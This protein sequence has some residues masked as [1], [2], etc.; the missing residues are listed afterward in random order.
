MAYR[1]TF[2]VSVELE[3]SEGKFIA[4]DELADQIIAALEG[5]DEG[6]WNVDESNYDT[7]DWAVDEAEPP[8]TRAKGG[9]R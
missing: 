9:R 8:K 1:F 2:T 7:T 5:A 3:R 6:S 4:R